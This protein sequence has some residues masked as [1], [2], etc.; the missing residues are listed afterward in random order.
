MEAGLTGGHHLC[1]GCM[2]APPLQLLVLC[3]PWILAVWFNGLDTALHCMAL[4]NTALPSTKQHTTLHDT[5]KHNCALHPTANTA[6]S[7][8]GVSPWHRPT[9]QSP[10]PTVIVLQPLQS[11][12]HSSPCRDDSSL[13]SSLFGYTVQTSVC[14]TLDI[15]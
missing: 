14:S 6:E 10:T 11:C 5:T 12:I 2:M 13:L 8:R 3:Y 4:H 1:W 9:L 15:F 7:T